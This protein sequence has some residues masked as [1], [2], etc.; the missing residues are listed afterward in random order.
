M[1]T[2]EARTDVAAP[3]DRVWGRLQDLTAWPTWDPTLERVEGT[4]AP[5]GRVTIHVADNPRPFRL[6]VVASEPG[7]RLLLRGG[8]PWGLFT[9]T[10]EYLLEARPEAAT[11][12][13]VRETYAGPLAR[14]VTRSIP[15]LQPSIEAFVGGLRRDAETGFATGQEGHR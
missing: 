8:L 7:S 10:R 11:G 6:R 1:T 2:F 3:T 12:L 14:L 4:L 13:T 15:D 9:G 5:A